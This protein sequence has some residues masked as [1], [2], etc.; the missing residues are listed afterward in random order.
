VSTKLGL[1]KQVN[2]AKIS[3]SDCTIS[4]Y[5]HTSG[6]GR[7]DLLPSQLDL[8]AVQHSAR[9][10]EMRLKKYIKEKASDLYDYVLID[11]PPTISI[12]IEA[13]ILASDKYVVPIKPDALSVVGLPLLEKYISD[14]TY[15]TGS[16]LE[17]VGIIFTQ[18]RTPTPPAMKEIMN[19]IRKS[20]GKAVFSTIS[21][22]STNVAESVGAHKPVF[23]YKKAS[24]KL[25]M[26]FVDITAEFLKR[27]GG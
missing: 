16:E 5:K 19:D 6:K 27:T 18:V 4:V 21:A 11:C 20:R 1:S 3:L 12:F 2:K 23:L 26:Q 22:V 13:A 9:Q 8:L 10:T 25:K 24:D 17:Q 7:L 14:Y 15:D